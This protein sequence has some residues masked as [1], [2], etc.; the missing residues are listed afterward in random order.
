MSKSPDQFDFS[1]LED[2]QKFEKLPKE[3]REKFIEAQQEEAYALKDLVSAG[4]A[5]NFERAQEILNELR[6]SPDFSFEELSK[7]LEKVRR[8][9]ENMESL[10]QENKSLNR[11]IKHLNEKINSIEKEMP[12]EIAEKLAEQKLGDEYDE[13]LKLKEIEEKIKRIPEERDK[14]DEAWKKE[15]ETIYDEE[16]SEKVFEEK[17]KPL[18]AALFEKEKN[19]Y[20]EKKKQRSVLRKLLKDKIKDPQERLAVAAEIEGTPYEKGFFCCPDDR[21]ELFLDAMKELGLEEFISRGGDSYHVKDEDLDAA[22]DY[23]IHKHKNLADN[24]EKAQELSMLKQEKE[25]IEKKKQEN[26]EKIKELEIEFKGYSKLI[27]CGNPIRKIENLMPWVIKFVGKENPTFV[28]VEA[29]KGVVAMLS[30]EWYYYGTGGC[31]YGVRATVM[32]DNPGNKESKY[33]KYRDPYDPRKDDWRYRFEE[34]EIVKIDEETVKV[35]LSKPS[36]KFEIEESFNVKKSKK[37]ERREVLSEEEQRAWKA[38]YDKIKEKLVE[39]SYL[40]NAMMP[41]YINYRFYEGPSLPP[42]AGTGRMVPYERPQIVDEYVDEEQGVGAIIIKSQI[43]HDAG[44]GKQYR[45]EGYVVDK[46]GNIKSVWSDNAYEL[47][48]RKGKRIEMKAADLLKLIEEKK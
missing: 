43:D 18:Y 8:I 38:N 28:K 6:K 24:P 21:P 48:L 37:P 42:G 44:F 10:I 15:A 11:S 36:E 13:Y 26:D 16:K 23:L 39:E 25:S 34:I 46:N 9:K 20:E 47:E 1:K 35:K 14:L 2:Q 19:L 27:R 33:Y 29:E 30:D 17:Y 41:D 31:E 3:E 5:S 32:R 22:K 7:S 12:K 4:V 45:W 40:P